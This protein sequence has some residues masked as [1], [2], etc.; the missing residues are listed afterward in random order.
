MR[1]LSVILAFSIVLAFIFGNI[2]CDSDQVTLAPTSTSIFTPTSTPPPTTLAPTDTATQKPSS[3]ATAKPTVSPMPT[4][5]IL[6]LEISQPSDGAHVSTSTVIVTGRTIPDAVV[7]LLVNEEIEIAD[8]DQ[9]GNFSVNIY[10]EEGPNLVEVIAS[11][12][13]GNENSVIIVVSYVL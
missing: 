9:N 2:G 8:V 3:T 13:Y 10:L 5:T 1:K 11:D 4:E 7:S 6:F 12:Q